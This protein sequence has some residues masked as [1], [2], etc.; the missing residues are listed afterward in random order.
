MD[1]GI[2]EHRNTRSHYPIST[3]HSEASMIG[4]GSQELEG[5]FLVIYGGTNSYRYLAPLQ[6][7]KNRVVIPRDI[8][9]VSLQNT[10]KSFDQ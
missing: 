4:S 2:I 6:C 1:D 7:Q 10:Y 5:I 9:T 3:D 8:V